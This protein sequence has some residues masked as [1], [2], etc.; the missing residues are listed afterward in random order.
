MLQK[1]TPGFATLSAK[2]IKHS[3]QAILIPSW[4]QKGS[5]WRITSSPKY[6]KANWFFP[7]CYVKVLN[8]SFSMMVTCSDRL[9]HVHKSPLKQDHVFDFQG[10]HKPQNLRRSSHFSSIIHWCHPS[11]EYWANFRMIESTTY[12]DD[13]AS[14]AK[15]LEISQKQEHGKTCQLSS[16]ARARHTCHRVFF[17]GDSSSFWSSITDVF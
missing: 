12:K 15:H 11:L 17:F 8:S 2:R 3:S 5:W 9:S 7:P 4:D 16:Y 10:Q 6:C 13:Y 14:A 1:N